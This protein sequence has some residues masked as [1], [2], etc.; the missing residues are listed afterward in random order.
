VADDEV[1]VAFGGGAFLGQ[2]DALGLSG[3][4]LCEAIA[5]DL[6]A[7]SLLGDPAL[8]ARALELMLDEQGLGPGVL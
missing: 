7:A 8:Q 4:H 5:Q 1:Q 2:P 6:Q 3:G